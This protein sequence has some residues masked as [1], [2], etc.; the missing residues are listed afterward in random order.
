MKQYGNQEFRKRGPLDPLAP[1]V[2]H[3]ERGVKDMVNLAKLQPGLNQAASA[4]HD[5]AFDG[6]EPISKEKFVWKRGQL[7]LYRRQFALEQTLFGSFSERYHR[8]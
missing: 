4:E 6:L 2:G 3:A 5:H 7:W 1:A 8:Q